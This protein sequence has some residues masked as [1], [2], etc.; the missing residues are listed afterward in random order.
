[1]ANAWLIRLAHIEKQ[2]WKCSC[3]KSLKR[4]QLLRHNREQDE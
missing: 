3:G 2:V 4:I 1:M